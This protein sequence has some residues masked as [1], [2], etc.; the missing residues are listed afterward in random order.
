M[1]TDDAVWCLAGQSSEQGQL[2]LV[3]VRELGQ[4]EAR[5]ARDYAGFVHRLLVGSGY[6]KLVRAYAGIERIAKQKSWSL[7][8]DEL[9]LNSAVRAL[10]IAAAD[11]VSSVCSSALQDLG[12]EDGA[13]LNLI[14]RVDAETEHPAFQLL[15]H[16]GRLDKG[17]FA[18]NG[19]TLSLHS[20]VCTE[21]G[22]HVQGFHER[23]DLLAALRNAL[24]VVQR[25]IAHQLEAYSGLIRQ[26]TKFLRFLAAEVPDGVPCL[27]LRQSVDDQTVPTNIST[28]DLALVESAELHRVLSRFSAV[29]ENSVPRRFPKRSVPT[30]EQELPVAQP[31]TLNDDLQNS[32]TLEDQVLDF[33]ALVKHVVDFTGD[34]EKSWSSGMDHAFQDAA[35]SDLKARYDTLMAIVLR[36]AQM[37]KK[38]ME[39]AGQ[40]PKLPRYPL[41]AADF[42]KITLDPDPQQALFQAQVAELDV[43][44]QLVSAVKAMREPSGR[45]IF[46]DGRPAETWWEAGAFDL[47]RMRAE[48]LVRAS[49]QTV[50][51]LDVSQVAAPQSDLVVKVVDRL[52]LAAN[53]F[54][55]G[56]VEATLLHSRIAILLRARIDCDVVPCDLFSKLAS[57]PR[58]RAYSNTLKLLDRSVELLASG[59]VPN[60]SAVTL[61]A[62]QAI[63]AAQ[64]ICLF[65]PQ[66]IIDILRVGDADDST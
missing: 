18:I 49:A 8:Q 13:Y 41:Q 32:E 50:M 38:K 24:L 25:L 52:T 57:D 55:R 14:D 16:I 21:L 5:K 42:E 2:A 34:L 48:Q 61:I 64:H 7:D 3:V 1:T 29:L 54:R 43:L 40:D 20:E 19:S 35:Q 28:S 58:L 30:H 51:S 65:D 31:Q 12:A 66:I 6:G 9:E 53:A 44:A 62:P 17:P 26:R 46:F 4:E 60:A 63:S 23:V 59:V 10:G 45:T 56:D 36:R 27:I 33:G 22:M 11:V 15:I 37:A 47:V 39:E